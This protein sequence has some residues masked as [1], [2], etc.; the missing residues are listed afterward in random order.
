MPLVC[1]KNQQTD[2]QDRKQSQ[3]RDQ[4]PFRHSGDRLGLLFIYKRALYKVILT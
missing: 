1:Y 4:V 3:A 2:A